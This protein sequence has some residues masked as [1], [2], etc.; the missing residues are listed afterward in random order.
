[1]LSEYLII[2][3][4]LKPQGIRGEVKVRPIT[5]DLNRFAALTHVFLKEGETYSEAPVACERIHDGFAYLRFDGVEDRD[6]AEQ[7]RGLLLYVHRDEAIKLPEG[8]HFIC[9]MIGCAVVNT[10]GETIGVLID[11]L[12]PGSNDVYVLDTKMGEVLLPALH[13]VVLDIDV[14]SKRI[15]VDEERMQEV[16]AYPE[17]KES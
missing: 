13:S 5:H 16:A 12:T 3:E 7:F 15:T 4:V 11:V 2:G 9:D 8:M 17:K 1:M 14:Y 10:R 6:T